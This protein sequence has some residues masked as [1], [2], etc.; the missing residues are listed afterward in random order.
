MAAGL[1]DDKTFEVLGPVL[2]VRDLAQ[3]AVLLVLCGAP[4]RGVHRGDN[5]VDPVGSQ[6]TVV[7]ALPQTVGVHGVSE[8]LVGVLVV[9]PERRGCHAKLESGLEVLQYL[10]PV[11]LVRRAATMTLVDDDKIEEIAGVL[12]EQAGAAFVAGDGLVGGEVH[13]AALDGLALYL[14]TGIGEG[15]EGLVFGIVNENVAVR[16]VKDSGAAI[17]AC[18]VPAA[19]PELP[20]YLEGDQGLAGAR[21]HGEKNA[22]LA[23]EDGLYGPVDGDLLVVAHGGVGLVVVGREEAAFD[24]SGDTLGTLQTVPEVVRRR[25]G[26]EVSID[27][28]EEVVLDDFVAVGGVG[29]I[30]REELTVLLRLLEAVGGVL[31]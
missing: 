12:A 14:V 13:F 28:G 16:Q 11:A 18:A 3:V 26:G 6:E 24:I 1:K 17:L 5:T 8:V 22:R 23:L 10:P 4:A 9:F 21:C 19:V 7:Y 29:E 27:S 25:K 31:V 2:C 20:A 15:G 30:Q